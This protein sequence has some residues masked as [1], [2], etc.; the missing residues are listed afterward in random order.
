MRYIGRFFKWIWDSVWKLA[1]ELT[2]FVIRQ[3]ISIIRFG[4]PYI[5]R[6]IVSSLWIMFQMSVLNFLALIRPIPDV[7]RK[8]AEDWSDQ[9]VRDGW[10]PSLHQLTLTRILTVVAVLAMTGGLLINL[11]LIIFTGIL[12]WEHGDWLISLLQTRR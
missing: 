9:A 5:F 8:A 1:K 11:S 4:A 3:I 12:L 10:F 7:A 6:I 2:M